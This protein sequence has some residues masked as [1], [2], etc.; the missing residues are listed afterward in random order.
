MAPLLSCKNTTL[1]T[2]KAAFH[3]SAYI[4][5]RGARLH[6]RQSTMLNALMDVRVP[7]ELNF[8][9]FILLIVPRDALKL[10][11]L[12]FNVKTL[13]GGEKR[14]VVCRTVAANS[15]ETLGAA[16]STSN[17]SRLANSRASPNASEPPRASPSPSEPL[18]VS[19]NPSEPPRVFRVR[20][21]LNYPAMF[22]AGGTIFTFHMRMR[23]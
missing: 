8:C 1:P 6:S 5:S 23:C 11:M 22:F 15:C 10:S 16:E 21:R 2:G 13:R 7:T 18:R 9:Y 12:L 19:P 4:G 20:P 3:N 17:H 14:S